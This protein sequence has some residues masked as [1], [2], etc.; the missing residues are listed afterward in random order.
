MYQLEKEQWWMHHVDKCD[1]YP[2]AA[3]EFLEIPA[4]KQFT[5]EIATNQAFTTFSYNGTMT[6]DWTDGKTHP[7]DFVLY[8]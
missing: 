2:P 7:E 8:S 6:S 3:G 1:E 4:G 5:V